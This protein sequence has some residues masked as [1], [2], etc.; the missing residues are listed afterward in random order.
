MLNPCDLGAFPAPHLSGDLFAGDL[1]TAPVLMEDGDK[2]WK[3]FPSP[4]LPKEENSRGMGGQH[5][6]LFPGIAVGFLLFCHSFLPLFP[7]PEQSDAVT[8]E[9]FTARSKFDLFPRTLYKKEL[10]L[11]LNTPSPRA[12][13]IQHHYTW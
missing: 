6:V 1:L 13:F 4:V 8:R 3:S 12:R 10:V 9:G 5:P 11:L 7:Q 2:G